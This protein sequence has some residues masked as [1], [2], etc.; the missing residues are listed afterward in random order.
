MLITIYYY[1]KIIV[2]VIDDWSCFAF[3]VTNYEKITY[4]MLWNQNRPMYECNQVRWSWI[5]LVQSQFLT[6]RYRS[7]F[8]DTI[9]NTLIL[10]YSFTYH[11][12]LIKMWASPN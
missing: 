9:N 1:I 2:I 3:D 4:V 5:S 8:T 11:L 12:F 10:H 6:L 7:Y